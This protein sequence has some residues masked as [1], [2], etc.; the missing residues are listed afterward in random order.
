MIVN[1]NQTKLQRVF[2]PFC[3]M[4]KVSSGGGG[5]MSKKEPTREFLLIIIK[6]NSERRTSVGGTLHFVQ[7]C[8][9]TVALSFTNVDTLHTRG[10]HAGR[11]TNFKSWWNRKRVEEKGGKS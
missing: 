1:N 11:T 9:E 3:L 6:K 7:P 8:T 4:L 10:R 2:F 5:G